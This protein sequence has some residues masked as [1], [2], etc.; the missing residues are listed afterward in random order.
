[1]RYKTD[2][3]PR[4]GLHAAGECA[5]KPSVQGR[6][7]SVSDASAVF[8]IEVEEDKAQRGDAASMRAVVDVCAGYAREGFCWAVRIAP[9]PLR[10]GG[11]ERFLSR[12]VQLAYEAGGAPAARALSACLL[13]K[14]SCPAADRAVER[15]CRE[16]LLQAFALVLEERGHAWVRIDEGLLVLLKSERAARRVLESLERALGKLF[17][18]PACVLGGA[19]LPLADCP[20]YGRRVVASGEGAVDVLVHPQAVKQ[21][22][23]LV[24][25]ATDR[26]AAY[27][28]KARKAM[29]RRARRMCQDWFAGASDAGDVVRELRAWSAD[30]VRMLLWKQ[31]KTVRG[32]TSALEKMLG[33]APRA[34]ALASMRHGC[35]A[36]ARSD[37]LRRALPASQLWRLG[38]E[39]PSINNAA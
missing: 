3:F 28:N 33:D 25:K 36:A 39:L 12:M 21:V 14:R 9:D 30:R 22:K 11:E 31:W 2:S 7:P 4:E 38:F 23:D 19:V 15:W 20:V 26:S 10:G 24:R 16:V 34:H 1:M 6:M 18:A 5:A 13:M 17:H 32:R 8:E 29:L 27:P 35:W 37:A